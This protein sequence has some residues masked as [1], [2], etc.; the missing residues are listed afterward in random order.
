MSRLRLIFTCAVAVA[1]AIALGSATSAR[2]GSFSFPAAIGGFEYKA[3]LPQHANTGIA[4]GDG[5]YV[6]S[7]IANGQPSNMTMGGS[8][9]NYYC[10][11]GS[12]THF[13][14]V[15]FSVEVKEFIPGPP[16][17]LGPTIDNHTVSIPA[18]MA[19]FIVEGPSSG[20]AG[21]PFS[22]TT[23]IYTDPHSDLGWTSKIV[24]GSLPAGLTLSGNGVLSGT[25][26]Q[27]GTYTFTLE[28]DT[29]GIGW[30]TSSRP[31]HDYTLT[32]SNPVVPVVLELTPSV[33]P[34]ATAYAPY[35]Q[36]L[37][38]G[39]GTAPYTYVITEGTLPPG[40]T[41]APTGALAGVPTKAG[42]YQ[43]TIKTTDALGFTTSRQYSV[44][45]GWPALRFEPARFPAGTQNKTYYGRVRAFDGR[46][47]YT[48]SLKAGSRR[49]PRGLT[50]AKNGVITGKPKVFG[51]FTF[52]VA[53]ADV[54][55]APGERTYTLK[56][57]KA[58]KVVKKPAAKPGRR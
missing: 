25:P 32:F 10:V 27:G 23:P 43:F 26:T 48:Y 57:A 31:R 55:G 12:P 9:D 11:V 17:S 58:K 20:Q 39:G 15:T 45:I 40:L 29:S 24:A 35:S 42:T 51:T 30:N 7:Y 28:Y 18:L 50:L 8:A 38:T 44:T 37:T 21:A 6:N 52:T 46:G 56:I 49:L 14:N 5:F 19:K 1:M 34:T 54:N 36:A 4:A 33:S 3:C 13:S 22:T 16:P 41:L 47:P 53:V 2:A